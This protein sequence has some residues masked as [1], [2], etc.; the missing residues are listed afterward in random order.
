M[1]DMRMELRRLGDENQELK[2]R[3]SFRAWDE[4]DGGR[5]QSNGRC[6]CVC[7]G[8]GCQSR[9]FD[10]AWRGRSPERKFQHGDERAT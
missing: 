8:R 9:A 5:S 7:G 6:Q 3:A 10:G 2:A 1:R 4:W